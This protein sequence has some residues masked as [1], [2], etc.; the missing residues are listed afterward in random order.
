MSNGGD[1][2]LIRGYLEGRATAHRTID[3]WIRPLVG[4]RHWGLADDRDDI[5]QEVRRRLY[6][7]LLYE[8]FAGGSSL[9]TYVSQIAKY[10]CIEFL[11]KR[12]RHQA[13]DVDELALAD[14]SP[15]PESELSGVE[16]TRLAR[17]ALASLPEGCRELFDLIFVEELPYEHIAERLGVAPGTVKSRAFRCRESLQKQ[18]KKHFSQKRETREP[19]DA[20]GH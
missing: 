4:S 2:E 1:Q 15:D 3:R 8:K 14:P 17:Q 7:N 16:R 6:E 12:K 13:A 10:V 19:E 11:R 18:W 9:R 20:I 5:L